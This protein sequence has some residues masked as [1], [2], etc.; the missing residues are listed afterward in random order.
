MIPSTT[1]KMSLH[2]GLW[3]NA[4]AGQISRRLNRSRVGIGNAAAPGRFAASR[5]SKTFRFESGGADAAGRRQGN[6]HID[7]AGQADTTGRC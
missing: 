6:R 5:R 2:T 3:Q 1:H 4:S 7:H